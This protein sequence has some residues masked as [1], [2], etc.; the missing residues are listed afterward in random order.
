MSC[1][2]CGR[3]GCCTSF[4]SIEQQEA[5]EQDVK[6]HKALQSA[7]IPKEVLAQIKSLPAERDGLKAALEIAKGIIMT[8]FKRH[9]IQ[10]SLEKIDKALESEAK[11][12]I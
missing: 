9:N 7:L 10:T 1:K 5:F 11:D 3:N 6:L 12:A 2:I 8:P 4:H